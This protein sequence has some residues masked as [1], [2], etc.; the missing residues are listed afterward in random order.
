FFSC[1]KQY[2]EKQHADD[3]C[4]ACRWLRLAD[5]PCIQL[6]CGHIFHYRCCLDVLKKGWRGPEVSFDF[7][8]CPTCHKTFEHPLL[9]Q[10]L[11]PI[12][13]L[14]AELLSRSIKWLLAKGER[15]PVGLESC[16]DW[17]LQRVVYFRCFKC[18]M[19]YFGGFR[20]SVPRSSVRFDIREMLCGGCSTHTA[21]NDLIDVAAIPCSKHGVQYLRYRC[22]ECSSI[23]VFF[24]FDGVH[25]CVDCYAKRVATVSRPS[26]RIQPFPCGSSLIYC[27]LEVLYGTAETEFNLGCSMCRFG[28]T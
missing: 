4:P 19:F 7:C 13:D 9:E 2:R 24:S 28:L 6:S 10:A 14:K 1:S 12:W 23:A 3:G 25:L 21:C 11:Q 16:S 15:L 18:K 22:H 5:A 20:D 26:E 17:P 8:T 27:P